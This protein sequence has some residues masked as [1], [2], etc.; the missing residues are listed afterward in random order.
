ME[1]KEHLPYYGL[2]DYLARN[3]ISIT[4]FATELEL[5]TKV[6]SSKINGYSDFTLTDIDKIYRTF[7]IRPSQFF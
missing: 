7:S 4:E 6:V 1:K 3:K 5:K 2:R